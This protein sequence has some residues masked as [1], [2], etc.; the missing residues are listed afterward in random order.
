MK[1]SESRLDV[2]IL[3]QTIVAL[4]FLVSLIIWIFQYST[5]LPSEVEQCGRPQQQD[6][7]VQF[8]SVTFPINY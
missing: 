1:I 2:R 6:A 4:G 3:Y 5:W 8:S 7:G